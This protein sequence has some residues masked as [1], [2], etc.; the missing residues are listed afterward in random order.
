MNKKELLLIFLNVFIYATKPLNAQVWG[1]LG[2][3]NALAANDHI[4]SICSDKYGNIYAAGNFKNSQ[5]KRYV[6]LWNG[7]NWSELGGL[8]A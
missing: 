6:A 2:G 3:L 4:Y 7:T 5:G 1:E 8:N